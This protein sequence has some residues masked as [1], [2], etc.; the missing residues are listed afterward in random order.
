MKQ[1]TFTLLLTMLLSMVGLHAY[2]SDIEVDGIYYDFNADS[3]TAT[4]TFKGEDYNSYNNEYTG[5]VVIPSEVTY[6]G[7]KY[8]VTSI[9]ENAFSLCSGLTSITIPNSVTSI[10][11][12]AFSGCS[13]L[14]SVTIPNSVTSIGEWAFWGCSGLTSVTIPNSV[15]SIGNGDGGESRATIKRITTNA[16]HTIGDN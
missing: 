5:A 10:G 3:K 7:E 2:A 4:V 14:T 6:G 13:G 11:N 8:S 12:S 15:M 16:R 1:T 9:G